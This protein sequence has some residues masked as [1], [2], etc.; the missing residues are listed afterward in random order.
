M[1]SRTGRL[2]A[3][4][5]LL[6]TAVGGVAWQFNRDAGRTVAAGG[7]GT[8]SQPAD[9]DW[10]DKA[11][12]PGAPLA[13]TPPKDPLPLEPPKGVSPKPGATGLAQLLSGDPRLA[14]FPAP[15]VKSFETSGAG[16]QSEIQY[17]LPSGAVLLVLQEQL[18]RPLPLEAIVS[19]GEH[20]YEK[21][22]DGSELVLVKRA[23]EAFSQ[24]LRITNDGVV[25]NLTAR[26]VPGRK[27][28]PPL[29]VDQLRE[30]A[31]NIT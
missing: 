25:Y 30:V 9:R 27:V 18:S 15:E 7:L 5:A 26:G 4:V 19:D 2:F 1:S 29:T 3:V 20:V 14:G 22:Q 6:A 11:P 23:P 12:L 17:R 8:A 28:A 31:I 21:L 10:V 13:A 16:P 24:A